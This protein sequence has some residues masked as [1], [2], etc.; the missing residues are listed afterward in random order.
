[1]QKN[2]LKITFDKKE[3]QITI[4]GNEEGLKYLADVCLRIIG[5]DTPAGHFHLMDN[6]N[7]LDKG[8]INTSIIFEK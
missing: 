1:M 6:M 5:K 3:N 4:I 8:S 7:N 2:K